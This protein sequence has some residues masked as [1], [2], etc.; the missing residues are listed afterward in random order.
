MTTRP[1]RERPLVAKRAAPSGR[2]GAA[3]PGDPPSA[4]AVRLAAD[5]K[6]LRARLGGFGH[7]L[8]TTPGEWHAAAWDYD[9]ALVVAAE[10]IGVPHPEP[11]MVLGRRRL[12]I[13]ERTLI[14]KGLVARGLDLGQP[15]RS[16]PPGGG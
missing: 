11:D 5:L 6:S 8:P 1:R 13:A 15:P 2:G 10:A 12:T 9:Q 7:D 3:E 16:L 4:Q 14:E